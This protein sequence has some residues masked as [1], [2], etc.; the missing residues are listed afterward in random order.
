[1]AETHGRERTQLETT[2]A[3]R[4][5]QETEVRQQNRFEAWEALKR[6]QPSGIARS[7]ESLTV[8]AVKLHK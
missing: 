2:L 3:V 5:A 8:V 7:P 6:D 1:M 4:W